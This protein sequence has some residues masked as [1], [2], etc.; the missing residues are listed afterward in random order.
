MTNEK[1]LCRN[2]RFYLADSGVNGDCRRY[3][4]TVVEYDNDPVFPMVD[5]TDW[6]GEWKANNDEAGDSRERP[7]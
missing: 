6:C 7:G 3:P 4:P 5:G 2:C 1:E